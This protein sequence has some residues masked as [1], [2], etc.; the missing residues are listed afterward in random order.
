MDRKLLKL[1]YELIQI[2]VV[3]C[4]TMAKIFGKPLA[5]LCLGLMLTS[6]LSCTDANPDHSPLEKAPFVNLKRLEGSWFVKSRIPTWFDK[7]EKN[8]SVDIKVK[9]LKSFD[10]AWNYS[11]VQRET[12]EKPA[13][14]QE[15][16]L[17][18]H[19]WHISGSAG[20]GS[21]SGQWRIFPLGPLFLNVQ[22]IEYSGDYS[23]IV[24]GS[25]DRKYA[26]ILSR[27]ESVDKELF[28]GIFSRLREFKFD[29]A[30][31]EPNQAHPKL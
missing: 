28:D 23:W 25:K 30:A 6:S 27:A 24:V 7:K 9:D 10:I 12:S 21:G 8:I 2:A 16:K 3:G 17:T 22:V 20:V 1:I 26:W 14:L 29:V 15:G 19:S 18:N 11:L 13:S 5:A 4:N 31:F